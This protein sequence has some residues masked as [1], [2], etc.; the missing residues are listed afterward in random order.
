[1]NR[2]I[3]IS[4]RRSDSSGYA[5]ALAS[6][7]A[8]QFGSESVFMDVDS[9]EPGVDFIETIGTSLD[10][11]KV[12]LALIG[13]NW[14]GCQD[15]SPP[16][17]KND[18]DY[19]RKEVADA[20][21][22]NVRVIPVL[23][24]NAVMPPVEDL[25]DDLKPLIR[26]H[27]IEW[28]NTRFNIDLDRIVV[29]TNKAIAGDT[30]GG[31]KADTGL[32]DL[33]V[34]PKVQSDKSK[35]ML[36]GEQKGLTGEAENTLPKRRAEKHEPKEEHFKGGRPSFIGSLFRLVF[37]I[38]LAVSVF[39]AVV[40]LTHH[41]EFALGAGATGFVFALMM[42]T[43]G[44]TFVRVLSRVVFFCVVVAFGIA[45]MTNV[46]RIQDIASDI[47]GQTAR[48]NHSSSPRPPKSSAGPVDPPAIGTGRLADFRITRQ[49]RDAVVQDSWP[50]SQYTK[51]D[52][53]Q[54]TVSF[55]YSGPSSRVCIDAEQALNGSRFGYYGVRPDCK[56]V[57]SGQASGTALL[58]LSTSLPPDVINFTSNQVVV[59]L[60]EDNGAIAQEQF[61][62]FSKTWTK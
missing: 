38:M 4:Y 3:F 11:C 39:Y 10:S 36:E 27:A 21:E 44:N 56:N 15:N 29:A 62:P 59:M 43:R 35:A 20:L 12:L 24:D 47:L 31:N 41:K 14:I 30:V 40:I 49:G 17:I 61:F 53:I 2:G 57:I 9:L 46:K 23:I 51:G 42:T 37:S 34:A 6:C 32:N 52:F 60:R 16:R 8:K 5:H 58:T 26:R 55:S 1:M 22:R 33:I 45:S 18:M 28:S 7:L 50:G 13:S 19:V 25:P 48:G 54:F